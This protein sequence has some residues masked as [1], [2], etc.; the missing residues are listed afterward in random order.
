VKRHASRFEFRFQHLLKPAIHASDEFREVHV[1]ASSEL[2]DISTF[3]SECKTEQAKS[4]SVRRCLGKW[5]V[6]QLPAAKMGSL[7]PDRMFS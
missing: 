4:R 6:H 3:A 5:L 1:L 7:L 2:F